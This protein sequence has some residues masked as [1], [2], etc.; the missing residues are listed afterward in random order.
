MSTSI[1][2]PDPIQPS[3]EADSNELALLLGPDSQ[4][5]EQNEELSSSDTAWSPILEKSQHHDRNEAFSKPINEQDS[6]EHAIQ[7]GPNLEQT[8]QSEGLS[9]SDTAWSPVS[10]EL[11]HHDFIRAYR[12][13]HTQ[14]LRFNSEYANIDKVRLEKGDDAAEDLLRSLLMS[15][16]TTGLHED[17][18]LVKNLYN[19]SCRTMRPSVLRR[20]RDHVVESLLQQNPPRLEAVQILCETVKSDS[21]PTYKHAAS[22]LTAYCEAHS[23]L[24]KEVGETE[25][26]LQGMRLCSIPGN[27][28]VIMPVIRSFLDADRADE[29]YDCMQQ[30]LEKYDLQPNSQILAEIIRGWGRAMNWS[31]ID[32]LLL[33]L[34][35]EGLSRS[36]PR[37]FTGLVY[38]GLS[39]F[40]HYSPDTRIFDYLTYSVRQLGVVPNKY[41]SREVYS[42]FI[43]NRRFDLVQKWTKEQQDAFP[44]MLSPVRDHVSAHYIAHAW[45]SMNASCTDVLNTCKAL[46][47]G[48]VRNPFSSSFRFLTTEILA[49]DLFARCRK[50]A[51]A[52]NATELDWDVEKILN[53]DELFNRVHELLSAADLRL[54]AR[55]RSL[56]VLEV[57]R[58]LDAAQEAALLIRDIDSYM[59]RYGHK[60]GV[61]EVRNT[62]NDPRGEVFK[63]TPSMGNRRQWL[64]LKSVS[65]IQEEIENL[66]MK[67]EVEELP[68]N[69]PILNEAVGVLMSNWHHWEVCILLHQLS[70]TK[71]AKHVFNTEVLTSWVTAATNLQG[72]KYLVD[73]LWAV[74]EAPP[75]VRLPASFLLLVQLAQEHLMKNVEK[76]DISLAPQQHKE[77]EYLKNRIFRRKWYQMG[78]PEPDRIIDP[79]MRKWRIGLDA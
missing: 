2:L 11:K 77:I 74:V 24:V 66:Y 39:H 53:M 68:D 13:S 46:A 59:V 49:N 51:V 7:L 48:Y 54:R 57:I 78:F 23:D 56:Q 5:L 38:Q 61:G 14:D 16:A 3:I 25:K 79:S 37:I 60:I 65:A 63:S 58:Q 4:D 12:N 40:G 30:L 33:R 22:Y 43:R 28:M 71:H 31:Q 62:T 15:Y 69:N 70:K 29:A 36:K 73:A 55:R 10:E 1:S 50:L 27:I 64:S 26:V 44:D 20:I 76:R 18:E 72:H 45:A 9:S 41:L 32:N 34:H 35:H 19:E 67:Q 21:P 17:W 42:R 52:T 6:D 75:S 8:G 47:H